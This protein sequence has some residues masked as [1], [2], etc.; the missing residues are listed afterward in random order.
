MHTISSTWPELLGHFF[1]IFTKP[2]GEIFLTLMT[3]WVL[4]TARRTVTGIL[5][6]ADPIFKGTGS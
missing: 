3:G 4:C 1:Q 2:G 6:F 5:P